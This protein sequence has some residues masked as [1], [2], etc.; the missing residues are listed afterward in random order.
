MAFSA[1][2]ETM[3]ANMKAGLINEGFQWGL[4]AT[5]E[6]VDAMLGLFA[7]KAEQANAS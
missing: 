3:A 2:P 7:Q 5:G 1:A 6:A 4:Y